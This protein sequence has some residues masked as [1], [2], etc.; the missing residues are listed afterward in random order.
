MD[1]PFCDVIGCTTPA[2][3]FY[4]DGYGPVERLCT[5]HW[6]DLLRTARDRALRFETTNPD[7]LKPDCNEVEL[8]II[9]VPL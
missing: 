6:N 3:R 5:V 7:R 1:V 8:P 4:S 9:R 2:D